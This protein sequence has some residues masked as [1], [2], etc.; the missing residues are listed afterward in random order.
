MAEFFF[1][2][3]PPGRA[4]QP[5]TYFI[6]DPTNHP[7]NDEG[8]M[9]VKEDQEELDPSCCC[10][11]DEPCCC[12]QFFPLLDAPATLTATI[13]A[14]DCPEIDGAIITLVKGG[15]SPC[16]TYTGEAVVGNC[17]GSVTAGFTLECT[18]EANGCDN[19]QL[20][21]GLAQANCT[22]SGKLGPFPSEAGCSCE[23]LDLRF[24]GFT[25]KDSGLAPG[26]CDCCTGSEEF[27]VN[28]T[29]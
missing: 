14:P 13:D 3:P 16:N 6:A 7:N 21:M 10:E 1:I 23:P 28:V 2:T 11:G 9:L 26:T 18:G 27:C 5:M 4:D 22:A 24:C 15:G 25:I 17:G 20:T 19:Y 8:A 29:E 12:P